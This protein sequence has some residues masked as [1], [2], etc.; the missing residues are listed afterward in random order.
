M[1]GGRVTVASPAVTR[2]YWPESDDR[3]R[4][5]RFVTDDLAVWDRGELRLVGRLSDTINV[6][7]RKVNPREVEDVLA[8][9]HGVIEVH[10]MGVPTPGGTDH[11]VRAVVACRAGALT[12]EPVLA[13]CREHLTDYKVPRS[14]VFVDQIPRT[15]RG[16]LDRAALAALGSDARSLDRRDG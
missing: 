12:A 10:V 9:L 8:G 4:D 6:K 2:G 11:I 1:Q 3:L 7:G 14:V 13:W 15:D 16:K 5:G